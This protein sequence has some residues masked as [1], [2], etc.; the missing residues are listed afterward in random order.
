MNQSWSNEVWRFVGFM[1]AGLLLGAMTGQYAWSLLAMTLIYLC[2]HLYH[3]YRLDQWLLGKRTGIPESSRG[4]WSE[5]YYNL[6]RLQQRN[7]RR[8]K[9]LASMVKRFRQST[10]ALPDAAVVMDAFG[11]IENWNKKA[12][13]ILKLKSPQDIQHPVSNY[14]RHPQFIQYMNR[15]DFDDSL[16]IT[17]PFDDQVQLS[18]KIVPYGKNQQ[19]LMV[20]DVT[21]MHALKQM[22]Q[23]FIANVSHELRT[24]LTVI[25]GYLEA[26]QDE[27]DEWVEANRNL[28]NSMSQQTLR[29]QNIVTDLLL[30]SRLETEQGEHHRQYVD[31]PAMLGMIAEDANVISNGRHTINMDVDQ[32]L[33][34]NANREEIVSAFSNLVYN[35]VKYT[36]EGG[37]VNVHWSADDEGACFNVSDTGNGIAPQ[38][39]P[40]LTERFYRVDVG[41]SR[42]SGGTGLGLAIVKHVLNRHQAN[43][44]IES[45]LG[46]GSS[47]KCVFPQTLIQARKVA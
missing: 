24:P 23:D 37:E 21:R 28:F 14:L 33:C 31:V 11:N 5:I 17:S 12:A 15:A 4:A 35:A 44:Q 6:Y 3:L 25:S 42:E 40:R 22:R 45:E 19:L 32:S 38:H 8:K 13:E 27:D 20:K 29:M 1:L 9:R 43:L 36:P 34:L 39:I 10:N 16:Q 46:K 18:I 2:L 41:R 7:R 47:F 30:L 26:L